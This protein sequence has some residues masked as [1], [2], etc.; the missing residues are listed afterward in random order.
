MRYLLNTRSRGAV[1]ERRHCYNH[2]FGV[3]PQ[4]LQFWSAGGDLEP[5]ATNEEG[6]GRTL[7]QPAKVVFWGDIP[8]EDGPKYLGRYTGGYARQRVSSAFET[9]DVPHAFLYLPV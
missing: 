6:I 8:T 1:P 4:K 2:C 3:F 9:H 5:V 7:P